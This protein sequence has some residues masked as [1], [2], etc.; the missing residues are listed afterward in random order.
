MATGAYTHWGP[1]AARF[2][3]V[4]AISGAGR[5]PAPP[6]VRPCPAVSGSLNERRAP[7]PVPPSAAAPPASFSRDAWAFAVLACLE[8]CS[9]R[10]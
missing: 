8:I 10:R 5:P 2:A 4:A 6:R 9:C 7:G 3:T 1:T